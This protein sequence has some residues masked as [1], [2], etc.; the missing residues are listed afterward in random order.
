MRELDE[1]VAFLRL[2]SVQDRDGL[3]VSLLRDALDNLI[4]EKEGL[5]VKLEAEVSSAK[6]ERDRF[7]S[8]LKDTLREHKEREALGAEER[9]S[10]T[11]RVAADTKQKEELAAIVRDQNAMIQTSAEELQSAVQRS[12]YGD[13]RC[14]ELE[15]KYT[16]ACDAQ[17]SDAERRVSHSCSTPSLPL[18]AL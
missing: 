10:L 5:E 14:A 9:T 17:R 13:M 11:L 18:L 1:A 12:E 3:E 8:I 16:Q 2:V 6:E 4:A 7:K 15:E